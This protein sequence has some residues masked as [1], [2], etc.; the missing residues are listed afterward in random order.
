MFNSRYLF[1][2]VGIIGTRLFNSYISIVVRNTFVEVT[3]FS[4]LTLRAKLS[5][6]DV[7]S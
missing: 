4:R 1:N 5:I 2:C 3:T 6:M 7:C